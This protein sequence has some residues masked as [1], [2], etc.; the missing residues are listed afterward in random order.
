MKYSSLF[1]LALLLPGCASMMNKGR[2][3][4][5]IDS[6]PSGA[7]ISLNGLEQGVTPLLY[8]YSPNDGT[9]LK[10]DVKQ[11]GYKLST[12][13]IR[14]QA[15]NG[16][17]FLDA[18]LFQIPYI[19]D[20]DSPDLYRVPVKEHTVVLRKEIPADQQRYMMP[21]TGVELGISDRELQGTLDGSSM[22]TLKSGPQKQLRYPEQF[23]SSIVSGLKGTWMDA[24][25]VR[26]GT[27]KGDEALRRAKVHLKA[28]LLAFKGTLTGD[29]ARCSGPVE[30]TMEWKFFSGVRPDSLL[31]TVT[32]TVTYY[33]LQERASELIGE[34]M[35]LGAAQLAD[36]AELPEIIAAVYGSSLAATKGSTLAFAKPKPIAFAGRKEMLSAL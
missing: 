7:T 32:S 36:R 18:L 13:T 20:H 6:V 21:V 31:H 26:T 28:K 5:T 34:A 25:S 8:T 14:P 9:E 2:A 15:A 27:Q 10:F 35:E 1:A 22:R 17:L 19:F 33:A 11:P 29:E 23:T 30:M 3:S 24:Q 12:L 4:I 16:V